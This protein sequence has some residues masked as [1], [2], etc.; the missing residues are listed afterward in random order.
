[1]TP[2]TFL[3]LSADAIAILKAGWNFLKFAQAQPLQP[4][5]DRFVITGFLWENHKYEDKV[6]SQAMLILRSPSIGFAAPP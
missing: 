3:G 1:M 2:W 6:V 4:G 5:D